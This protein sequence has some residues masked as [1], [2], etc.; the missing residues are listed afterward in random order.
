SDRRRVVACPA[1]R[2]HWRPRRL[3]IRASKARQCGAWRLLPTKCGPHRRAR[4]ETERK[5]L[6][7]T[8]PL[9]AGPCAATLNLQAIPLRFNLMRLL[10]SLPDQKQARALSDY[11]LTQ[12][13]ATKLLD[14]D[15]GAWEI[16]VQ[17]E[18]QVEAAK[19]IWTDFCQNPADPRFG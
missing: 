16:W 8:V 13:I 11:L 4:T 14:G 12:N 3:T 7:L 10:S 2:R 18:D 9:R 15:R 1:R 5:R 17:N 6:A 19:A